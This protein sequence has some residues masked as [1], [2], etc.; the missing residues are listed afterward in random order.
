MR[1][2]EELCKRKCPLK[3]IFGKQTWKLSRFPMISILVELVLHEK[4]QHNKKQKSHRKEDNK[5]HF[6]YIE[7]CLPIEYL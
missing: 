2:L 6:E 7:F 1:E 3:I 5:L 4:Q